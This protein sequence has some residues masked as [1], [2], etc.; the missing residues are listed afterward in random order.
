[1]PKVSIEL[2]KRHKFVRDIE[3]YSFEGKINFRTNLGNLNIRTSHDI[4]IYE[5]INFKKI[6]FVNFNYIV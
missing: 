1:M 4:K 3:R 5:L 2:R 6:G